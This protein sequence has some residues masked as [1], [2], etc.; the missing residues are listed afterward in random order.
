MLVVQLSIFLFVIPQMKLNLQFCR[1]LFIS[2]AI[3]IT[4][5][6]QL[7]LTYKVH[8]AFVCETGQT[9][10]ICPSAAATASPWEGELSSYRADVLPQLSR[11]G[12][13]APYIHTCMHACMQACIH[14][15]THTH[16]YK[17]I[18]IH[19]NT[20]LQFSHVQFAF[21]RTFNVHC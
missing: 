18:Y 6:A 10:G 4:V 3:Q 16:T 17:H 5:Y 9:V 8:S 11:D 19:I 1:H 21:N 14:T 13:Y 15:H 7:S 20:T 2:S 12:E